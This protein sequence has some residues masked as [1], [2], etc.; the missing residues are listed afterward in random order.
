MVTKTPEV[1]ETKVPE[2][3]EGVAVPKVT[4]PAETPAPLMTYEE[5]SEELEKLIARATAAGLRP[6]KVLVAT[7]AKRGMS[8][9]ED[10]L[11]GLDNNPQKKS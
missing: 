7:Y 10:F 1:V 6:A 5:F 8:V 9:L 3:V 4:E 11:I 2:K